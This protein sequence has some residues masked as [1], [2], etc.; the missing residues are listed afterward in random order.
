MTVSVEAGPAALQLV[1]GLSAELEVVQYIKS[2]LVDSVI[3]VLF[4]VQVKA[5]PVPELVLAGEQLAPALC[6][7]GSI[8]R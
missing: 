6:I 8:R 4:V 7:A 1:E 3:L 2:A 5:V